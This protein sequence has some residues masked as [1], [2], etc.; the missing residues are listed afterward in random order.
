M[1]GGDL[2]VAKWD[3]CVEGGHDER[4]SQHVRVDQP[5]PG[6]LADA[7]LDRSQ[8]AAIGPAS[9]TRARLIITDDHP[10]AISDCVLPC[11]E[12][13][14]CPHRP[15]GRGQLPATVA[16]WHFNG[17]EVSTIRFGKLRLRKRLAGLLDVDG[18]GWWSPWGRR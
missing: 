8:T 15:G 1:A 16:G 12:V 18:S 14:K 9:S 4:G 10:V 5:E 13:P 3:T 6:S 17:L 7:V 2:H 11:P